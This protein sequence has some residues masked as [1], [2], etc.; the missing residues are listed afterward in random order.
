MDEFEQSDLKKQTDD[1][2][3]TIYQNGIHFKERENAFMKN[4]KCGI[5]SLLLV[6]KLRGI[7]AEIF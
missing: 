2:R 1:S 6:I 3:N 4:S 7:M 5:F